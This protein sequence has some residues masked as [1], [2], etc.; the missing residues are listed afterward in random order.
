MYICI[1]IYVCMCVCKCI[2]LYIFYVYM[3]TYVYIF[4]FADACI[5]IHWPRSI[6]PS[7]FS[8]RFFNFPIMCDNTTTQTVS[9]QECVP[10]RKYSSGIFPWILYFS[11]T[12]SIVPYEKF[13]CAFLFRFSIHIYGGMLPTDRHTR[14]RAHSNKLTHTRTYTHTHTNANTPT[15]THTHTTLR[16]STHMYGGML[17]SSLLAPNGKVP[18]L[19]FTK[20]HPWFQP[21]SMCTRTFLN[22]K[23]WHPPPPPCD[24]ISPRKV[25]PLF[26]RTHYANWRISL[27]SL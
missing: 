13:T 7:S 17:P 26:L 16:F 8:F 18:H 22:G 10:S 21:F 12:C 4:I 24:F 6:Y 11:R 1:C 19:F 20:P 9:F 5:H 25:L 2:Y 27:C 3:N 23:V 14:T 15:H